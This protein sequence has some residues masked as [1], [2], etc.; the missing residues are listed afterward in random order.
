MEMNIMILVYKQ[1][2]E[3]M[4]NIVMAFRS[5]FWKRSKDC[6]LFG[7]WFGTKYG[8]N[9]RYLF[10]YLSDH[11][12]K[13][14]LKHV[15]WVSRDKNI[16]DMIRS[17]GYEAYLMTSKE[18]I[19]YH[20]HCKYHIICESCNNLFTN[21]GDIMGQYS[22]GAIKINLW[23]GSG[24]LKNVDYSIIT[25]NKDSS[26]FMKF[27]MFLHDNFWFY[28]Y[29]AEENG[30]WGNCYYLSSS[31]AETEQLKSFFRLKNRLFIES[32]LPRNCSLTK[33]LCNEKAVL[34]EIRKYKH[35]IFYLPTFR[36][37]D[38]TYNY[39]KVYGSISQELKDNTLWLQ[40]AHSAS[41]Q[42]VSIMD[43]KL[44]FI[45]LDPSFDINIL[46]PF[47][48][49]IITDYSS[50]AVDA[51]YYNKPIIYYIPDIEEYKKSDRGFCCDINERM[52][53]PKVYTIDGLSRMIKEILKNPD[54]VITDEYIREKEKWWEHY[55]D[56]D[57][58]WIDI[59]EKTQ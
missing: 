13:L 54:S 21:D 24:A 44:G 6:I 59:Q 11:K 9:P 56:I 19:Y 31:A 47:T 34:E 42:H 32:N 30:G 33:V 46:L 7:A 27:K 5:M 2:V 57:Q 3:F 41:D 36:G 8:D 51:L 28:R 18:S 4:Y 12:E 53:G 45:D 20:K 1:F 29:F 26:V 23:H 35:I 40:K 55:C 10:Q 50:V 22:Y 17:I 14:G 58:I 16:V 52:C 39:Q 37:N 48:S 43:Q 15:I 49:M 38:S 25:N